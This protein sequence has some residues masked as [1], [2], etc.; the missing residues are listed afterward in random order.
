[1]RYFDEYCEVNLDPEI[2]PSTWVFKSDEKI[3]IRFGVHL[4]KCPDFGQIT[5]ESNDGQGYCEVDR[6]TTQ[7]ESTIEN[8]FKMFCAILPSISN[9]GGGMNI[10]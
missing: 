5:Y 7:T 10:N 1:M 8:G 4:S 6:I 9:G 2:A 3:Y